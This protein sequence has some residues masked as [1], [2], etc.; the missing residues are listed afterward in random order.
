MQIV[1]QLPV[2]IT[3]GPCRFFYR[4]HQPRATVELLYLSAAFN[5]PIS[6][7]YLVRVLA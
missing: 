7:S 2:V 4:G 5:L 6:G 3:D 1:A